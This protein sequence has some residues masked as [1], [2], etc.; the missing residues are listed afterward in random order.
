MPTLSSFLQCLFTRTSS[1]S[2]TLNNLSSTVR[3]LLIIPTMIHETKASDPVLQTVMHFHY[4]KW[5]KVYT[6]KRI[7][8][9]F[10]PQALLS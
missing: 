5:P 10:Q 6:D 9:F 4:T 1:S 7:Q 3:A 2:C 8:P